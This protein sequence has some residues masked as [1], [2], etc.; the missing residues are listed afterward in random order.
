MKGSAS[1]CFALLSTG[2][3]LDGCRVAVPLHPPMYFSAF[4]DSLTLVNL[5]MC[6]NAMPSQER[7]NEEKNLSFFPFS[8]CAAFCRAQR[9]RKMTLSIVFVQEVAP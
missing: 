7:C 3:V 5:G 8:K 4:S 9:K 6:Q 2:K 1:P